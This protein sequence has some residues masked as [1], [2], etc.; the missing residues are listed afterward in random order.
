MKHIIAIA[1]VWTMIVFPAIGCADPVQNFREVIMETELMVHDLFDSLS[2]RHG[3]DSMGLEESSLLL[4]D[5][6]LVNAK[7]LEKEA[8]A[9]GKAL[10]ASEA[11]HMYEDLVRLRDILS[12]QRPDNIA[13]SVANI[14]LHFNHCLMLNSENLKIMLVDHMKALK[15]AVANGVDMEKIAYDAEHLHLHA[16]QMYYTAILVGKKIWQKFAIE[17]RKS[18]EEILAAAER[19]DRKAVADGIARIEKP[20][21][22]LE[23]IVLE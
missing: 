15:E 18:A 3:K 16:D 6:L 11:A 21:L 22:M 14:Y 9:M 12:A 8:V 19:G 5:R 10:S 23:R 1:A 17:A 4:V 7:R 20:V 13:K 2:R